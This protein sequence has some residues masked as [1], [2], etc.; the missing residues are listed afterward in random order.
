M[1]G[2]AVYKRFALKGYGGYADVGEYCAARSAVYDSAALVVE[3]IGFFEGDRNVVCPY[4]VNV[5]LVIGGD[6]GKLDIGALNGTLFAADFVGLFV[7]RGD[8][9][10]AHIYVVFV[11][12]YYEGGRNRV[13]GFVVHNPCDN[14]NLLAL[15]CGVGLGNGFAADGNFKSLA[16]R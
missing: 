7:N 10:I 3:H 4:G 13:F 8:A 16:Y 5:R 2:S 9:L 1:G 6:V 15:I 14:L 11:K 12:T